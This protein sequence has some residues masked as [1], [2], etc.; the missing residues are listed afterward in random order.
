M[1]ILFWNIRGWGQADRRRQ[2]IE[3]TRYEGFEI[4]GIQETIKQ[5]F[6]EKE[7]AQVSGG[8]H[9][10]WHWLSANGHSGGILL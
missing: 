8:L 4:V 3:F 5:D 10:V 9:F 1:K 7:L 6:T 2:L